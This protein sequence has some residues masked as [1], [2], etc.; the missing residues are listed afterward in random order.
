MPY[1]YSS[2]LCETKLYFFP[3]QCTQDEEE[4]HLNPVFVKGEEER[5][6]GDISNLYYRL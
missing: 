6:D 1:T 4:R 2:I 5:E 3:V